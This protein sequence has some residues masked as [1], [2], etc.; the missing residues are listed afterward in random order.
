MIVADQ[1]LL[2]GWVEAGVLATD[3][4]WPTCT[5]ITQTCREPISTAMP[6]AATTKMLPMTRMAQDR[7]TA[8]E[9]AIASFNSIRCARASSR[10]ADNSCRIA[11]V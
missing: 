1:G 6:I 4:A 2:G 10:C 11:A 8:T 9:D 5:P 3:A 7:V